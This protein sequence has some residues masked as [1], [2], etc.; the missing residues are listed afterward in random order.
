M[1]IS[2]AI[3]G[4]FPL[5]EQVNIV[6]SNRYATMDLVNAL[7][8]IPDGKDYKKWFISPETDSSVPIH[9]D[10]R[11]RSTFQVSFQTRSAAFRVVWP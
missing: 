4:R 10:L 9:S 7:F 2:D 3:L 5:L 6:S 1:L 8:S 11:A